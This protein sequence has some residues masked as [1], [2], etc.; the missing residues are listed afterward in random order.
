MIGIWGAYSNIYLIVAGVA[1]LL[2]FGL[3]L[4]ITPLGWARVFRW[5]LPQPPGNL[6]VFLGRSLGVLI[7]LVAIFAIKVT[8][9][10]AAKPFFFDFM[11]WTF[12]AMLA[13]HISGMLRKTQ[14]VTENYEIILWVMLFLVTL[15]FYP[16]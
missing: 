11:L 12:L 1:M 7:S 2:A 5:E 8:G 16:V 15:C 3:P 13:L 6:V 9:I 14:P 10:P 4:M